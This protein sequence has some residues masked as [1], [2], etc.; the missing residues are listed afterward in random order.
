MAMSRFV[1][2]AALL[3]ACS[4][5]GA[6]TNTCVQGQQITCGCP[7]DGM[8]VQVCTAAGS[9]G[10]CSCGTT[11]AGGDAA[12]IQDAQVVDAAAFQDAS[13]VDAA[14]CMAKL[15]ALSPSTPTASFDATITSATRPNHDCV[16]YVLDVSAFAS[17]GM[18][19]VAGM[20]GSGGAT[21]STYLVSACS[22]VVGA[23]FSSLKNSSDVPPGQAW[24]WT[25]A[26]PA[27]SPPLY[28]G[29]EG[30]WGTPG[31]T[32]TEAVTVSAQ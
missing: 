13:I 30:G 20:N 11:D 28:F 12:S 22:D 15:V 18:L 2:L 29:L 32:N 26:F 17:G 31:Q 24:Q 16:W 5:S 25:Y 1:V 14:G 19:S 21:S 4:S 7:N 23:G 9:Y 10:S 27:N 3:A 8:G 6:Q